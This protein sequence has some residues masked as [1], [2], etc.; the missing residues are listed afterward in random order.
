MERTIVARF[1]V[2]MQEMVGSTAAG[3]EVCTRWCH[4]SPRRDLP[5]RDGLQK[6]TNKET[7]RA[8]TDLDGQSTRRR[9]STKQ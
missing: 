5:G 1:I 4:I 8:V 2:S 3:R 9:G 7:K 6:Q